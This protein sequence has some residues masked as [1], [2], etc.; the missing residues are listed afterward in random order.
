MPNKVM[1]AY[2]GIS[3]LKKL[4]PAV[5]ESED[6]ATGDITEIEETDDSMV[7]TDGTAFIC[8]AL[9]EIPLNRT[10]LMFDFRYFQAMDNWSKNLTEELVP[11]YFST[12]IGL[13]F[14]FF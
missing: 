2:G 12:S 3:F 7:K 4:N 8:G 5:L 6:I 9:F 10:Y 13:G 14:K 11:K 1:S